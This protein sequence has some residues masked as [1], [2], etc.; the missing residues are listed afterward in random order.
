MTN[1]TVTVEL[2]LAATAKRGEQWVTALEGYSPAVGNS[3]RLR[4]EITISLDAPSLQSAAATA[5]DVLQ[6]AVGYGVTLDN[7]RVMT[8][9]LFDQITDAIRPADLPEL[10]GVTEAAQ[11][12]RVSRQY[13]SRLVNENKIRGQLVGKSTVLLKAD[14]DKLAQ[15]RGQVGPVHDY[16]EG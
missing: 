12:M 6:R 10:I 5:T 13:L 14:I 9:E 16:G 3:P 15:E 11:A 4:A 2:P 1:Y 7:L 8:S